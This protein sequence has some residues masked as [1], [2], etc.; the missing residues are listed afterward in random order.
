MVD[1]V[2]RLILRLANTSFLSTDIKK[3]SKLLE[4]QRSKVHE[5]F[6][7]TAISY[8]QPELVRVKFKISCPDFFPALRRSITRDCMGTSVI[9]SIFSLTFDIH[10]QNQI[11]LTVS[12]NYLTK[13]S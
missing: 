12:N 6:Y 9:L 5:S 7:F 13:F 8:L 1:N 2:G 3:L 10:F 4:S 11:F